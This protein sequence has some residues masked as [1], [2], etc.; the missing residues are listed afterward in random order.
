MIVSGRLQ[1]TA[2]MTMA[3]LVTARRHAIGVFVAI[4]A[5]AIVASPS[6][7]IADSCPTH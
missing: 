6:A 3:R 7:A 1:R 2:T 5:G 4:A